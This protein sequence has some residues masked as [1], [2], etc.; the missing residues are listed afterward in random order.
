MIKVEST[1][2][3]RLRAFVPSRKWIFYDRD[4]KAGLQNS[5]Y[6]F[7]HL[8]L[9]Q[10]TPIKVLQDGIS[11][12]DALRAHVS[13]VETDGE[14][15]ISSSLVIEK[16]AIVSIRKLKHKSKFWHDDEIYGDQMRHFIRRLEPVLIQQKS[17]RRHRE[18]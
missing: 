16:E 6:L 7:R 9:Y 2:V 10:P 17:S 15:A 14:S 5:R 4:I 18:D 13:C 8:N 1:K 3:V 11:N 12:S